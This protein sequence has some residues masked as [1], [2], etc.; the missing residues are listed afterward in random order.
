MG[1]SVYVAIR[2]YTTAYLG[3]GKIPRGVAVA[4]TALPLPRRCICIRADIEAPTKVECAALKLRSYY[5]DS[6]TAELPSY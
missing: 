5:S 6:L 3:R 2:G 4:Q 1:S